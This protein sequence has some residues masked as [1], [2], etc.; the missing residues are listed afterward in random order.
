MWSGFVVDSVHY[1][2][3]YWF[4]AIALV[5]SPK[6]PTVPYLSKNSYLS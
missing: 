6:N 4:F 2:E 3:W 1:P 5:F